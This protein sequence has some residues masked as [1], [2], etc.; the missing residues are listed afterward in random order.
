[1]TVYSYFHGHKAYYD[2]KKNDWFY[3]NTGISATENPKPCRRCRHN[4]IK[5]NIFE[6]DGLECDYC[7]GYLGENV[8]SAC[9]GHGVQK[10][11]ILFKDGRLFEEVIYN[12]IKNE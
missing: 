2:A 6:K 3:I 8:K 7:L 11:Y 5:N 4:P 12:D 10:G 1:M 9:C